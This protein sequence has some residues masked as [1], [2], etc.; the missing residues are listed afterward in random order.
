MHGEVC[1]HPNRAGASDPKFLEP[2][3]LHITHTLTRDTATRFCIVI[4]PDMRGKL[5]LYRIDHF[6]GPGQNFCVTN[7]DAR[8]VRDS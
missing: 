1:P 6:P 7:A 4:K 2:I 5:N 3:G 8:P